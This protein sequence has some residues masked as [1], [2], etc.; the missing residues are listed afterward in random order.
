MT[1]TVTYTDAALAYALGASLDQAYL[2]D[3]RLYA[4]QAGSD[5]SIYIGNAANAETLAIVSQV[6]IGRRDRAEEVFNSFC[7]FTRYSLQDQ[8][9][10]SCYYGPGVIENVQ[11]LFA[12]NALGRLDVATRIGD[13]F[14]SWPVRSD[15][16]M[17]I[18]AYRPGA[19]EYRAERDVSHYCQHAVVLALDK[20]AESTGDESYRVC[21]S[22]LLDDVGCY[23]QTIP[24]GRYRYPNFWK[25]LSLRSRDNDYSAQV[26]EDILRSD[27]F[28]DE[29]SLFCIPPGIFNREFLLDL[30][31][32]GIRALL[33]VGMS[34]LAFEV[35][36]ATLRRH[37]NP[38]VGLLDWGA[39][40]SFLR[41]V[42]TAG[43]ADFAYAFQ[44]CVNPDSMGILLPNDRRPVV[45]ARER[46][47][48]MYLE[49]A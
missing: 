45:P 38:R 35:A 49:V 22:D 33:A 11:M 39:L 12:A 23:E 28:F 29:D 44:C 46:S 13:A 18:N 37:F 10:I 42:E 5:Q 30:Q 3:R 2:P 32:K 9:L 31:A 7:E 1:Q 19:K 47:V 25:V 48:K 43:N 14:L 20:L 8:G 26:M 40:P 6:A 4:T 36:G 27:Y 41:H 34:D 16:M 17:Y 15:G 24:K 21:A